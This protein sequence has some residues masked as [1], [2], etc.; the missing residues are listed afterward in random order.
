[1]KNKTSSFFPVEQFIEAYTNTYIVKHKTKP[2]TK[3]IVNWYFG[4]YKLQLIQTELE[5]PKSVFP[6]WCR[7]GK[8]MATTLTRI[9][10]NTPLCAECKFKAKLEIVKKNT[11]EDVYTPGGR[12]W[13]RK[14]FTNNSGVCMGCGRD[15]FTKKHYYD[16]MP[17]CKKCSSRPRLYFEDIE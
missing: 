17:L 14:K 13:Y 15:Y 3:N 6:Y 16:R 2:P 5:S 12:G 10:R 7:C 1:M 4:W 8:S 9:K 11:L